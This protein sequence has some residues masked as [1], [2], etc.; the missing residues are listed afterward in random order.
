[1]VD[2]D[3]EENERCIRE[4]EILIARQEQRIAT[5][6]KNGRIPAASARQ[7]LNRYRLSL[8]NARA[9]RHLPRSSDR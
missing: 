8:E 5:L 3:L 9:R 7:L 6:L 1:M 2:F 4:I